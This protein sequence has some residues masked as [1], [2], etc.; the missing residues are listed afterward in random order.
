MIQ[1]PLT[2]LL[3]HHRDINREKFLAVW[4]ACEL[5]PWNQRRKYERN[6][7]FR[8]NSNQI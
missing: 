3:E 5:E 2:E 1:E 7:Q 8:T 6:F 4:K